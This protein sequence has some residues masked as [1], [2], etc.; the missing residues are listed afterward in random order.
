MAQQLK[1]I[2]NPPNPWTSSTT[3][4]LDEPPRFKLQVFEETAKSI[5]AHNDSPDVGFAYSVNPYRGCFHG[6][7]YCYARPTHQYLD[8]GAG[9]DFERKI[10]VKVNAPELLRFEFEKSSWKGHGLAFSGVTDCYQPLEAT[11]CLTR[12]CLEIC[13]EYHNP[14]SIITKGALIRRDIDILVA[15][16]EVANA[17]VVHSIAF[18]DDAMSRKIEP[19]APRPSIRFRAM[20]ELH[21]AGI[22]V[23]VGVAPVIPGLNDSQIPEILELAFECGARSAFMTLLRLPREVKPVFIERLEEAFPTRSQ[24]VLHQLASMK[25][26]VLNKAEFGER[27][28]GEGPQWEAIQWLFESTCKKL[29]LNCEKQDLPRKVSSFQRPT[30][31]LSLF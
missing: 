6:C 30:K 27:M 19:Y 18:S 14:V 28:V 20:R 1:Y 2:S 16:N 10:V 25:G 17:E 7:A 8:F 4:W 15:L 29:G 11:Y 26:G 9:T 31:Q 13:R 12:R 24:K 3:E 22:K 5:V 23:A 21:E